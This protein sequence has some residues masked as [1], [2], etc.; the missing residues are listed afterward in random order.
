MKNKK[1]ISK[2]EYILYLVIISCVMVFAIALMAVAAILQT[3]DVNPVIY[4]VLGLSSFIILI[5]GVVFG[6][7]KLGRVQKYELTQKVEKLEKTELICLEGASKTKII[8]YCE[9]KKYNLIENKYYHKRR[10]SLFNDYIN[11]FI[12][13][14]DK[15]AP[16][17]ECVK[18][19]I[20]LFDQENRKEKNK[21]LIIV[22][23]SETVTQADLEELK[24]YSLP[25]VAAELQIKMLGLKYESLVVA[26]LDNNS[27]KLYAFN[28]HK[29]SSTMNSSGVNLLR[30][31]VY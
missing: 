18:K 5:F 7:V 26:L 13:L 11:Y 3:I 12:K 20:Q 29:H 10:F 19:Q 31:I 21:C 8:D 24:E 25:L 16:L 28:E 22:L 14:T 17:D 15:N 9:R 4:T 27:G 30:R 23:F 6:I 2:K 1:E